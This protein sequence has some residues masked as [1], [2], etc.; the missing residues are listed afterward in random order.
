MKRLLG[1]LA[2]IGLCLA[3]WRCH[4]G[5]WRVYSQ[6]LTAAGS[7]LLYLATFG[8]FGYY[9]LMTRQ[10]AGIFLTL[11]VIETGAL[12]VL[13]EAPAIAIMAL[14]GGLLTPPLLAADR[15]QYVN[16]FLFLG[17]LNAGVIGIRSLRRWPLLGTV[18]LLGTQLLFWLWFEERYH[19]EKRMAAALFQLTLLGLH[20]FDTVALNLWRRQVAALEDL[21]RELLAAIFLGWAGYV[22]FDD[23]YHIWMGTAALVLASLFALIGWLVLRRL[24][25][26][27]AHVG[28]AVA[29][30][31]A[32]VAMAIPLEARAAWI[33][34][35]WAVQ[36]LV[37]WW[38]GLRLRTEFLRSLALVCLV[39]GVLRLL[40]ETPGYR[41]PFVPLFNSYALPATIVISCLFGSAAVTRLAMQ[42]GWVRSSDMERLLRLILGLASVGLA[43]FVLSVETHGFF[44]ALNEPRSARTAL[45]M[46]WAI[47]A[48]IM[49][50]LGFRFHVPALRWAALAIFCMTLLKVFLIDMADLPGLYRVLAFFALALTLAAAA[51][52]Y[53]QVHRPATST[54][55][56]SQ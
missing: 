25:A 51:W 11:L 39:I 30:A 54:E 33:P 36:G 1:I 41:E 24:P 6:M 55:E 42:R 12:A 2:G 31:M 35:G 52:G 15:D 18:A 56:R 49:L 21:G 40:L 28:V 26:D 5:G 19:P 50:A 13:Y 23:D 44:T 46:V 37:L 45:S 48:S 29:L 47:Y 22:L 27:R 20:L 53:Q 9:H 16:L 14:I 3:G 8:A 32:F 7:I 10:P 17:L 38:F 43:W 4:R 34:V